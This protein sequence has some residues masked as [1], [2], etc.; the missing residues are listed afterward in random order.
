MPLW[1]PQCL[2]LLVVC[3]HILFAVIGYRREL[4]VVLEL[5]FQLGKL[6]YDPFAFFNELFVFRSPY[7]AVNIVNALCDYDWPALAG[8]DIGEG[9]RIAGIVLRFYMSAARLLQPFMSDSRVFVSNSIFSDVGTV[10]KMMSASRGGGGGKLNDSIWGR[11][12]DT[13]P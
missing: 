3:R 2:Q 4:P 7:G 1:V 12:S 8:R 5:I 11:G 13:Y 10:V 6:R 9:T